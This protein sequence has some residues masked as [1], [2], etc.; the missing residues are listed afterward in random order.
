MSQ[1]A[2]SLIHVLAAEEEEMGPSV[3]SPEWTRRDLGEP[4]NR[5]CPPVQP[6]EKV[7][8]WR[9]VINIIVFPVVW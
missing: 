1:D 5:G 6:A 3:L 4:E 2:V 9:K 8:D 7:L